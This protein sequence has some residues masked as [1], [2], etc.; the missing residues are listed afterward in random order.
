[1]LSICLAGRPLRV[2]HDTQRTDGR[3]EEDRLTVKC[4][5]ANAIATPQRQRQIQRVNQVWQSA[6]TP[7]VTS[8]VVAL[9]ASFLA[10]LTPVS[11]YPHVVP[12]QKG[13]D[14]VPRASPTR[15]TNNRLIRLVTGMAMDA[16][17]E[18]VSSARGLWPSASSSLW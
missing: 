6:L 12:Q 5:A 13:S 16:G 7:L 1:M 8:V 17:V 14:R 4:K 9:P 10:L 3:S 15:D 11:L 2:D 18:D